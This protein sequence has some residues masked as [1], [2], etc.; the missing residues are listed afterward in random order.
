MPGLGAPPLGSQGDSRQ[1]TEA[2]GELLGTTGASLHSPFSRVSSFTQ[3]TPA[4][5]KTEEEMSA[6]HRRAQAGTLSPVPEPLSPALSSGHPATPPSLLKTR[7]CPSHLL[8]S[9][10][11]WGGWLRSMVDTQAQAGEEGQTPVCATG[12]HGD[13]SDLTALTRTAP[14]LRTGKGIFISPQ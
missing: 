11:S 14:Q 1:H 7:T 12:A 13:S 2:G 10:Q 4:S 8:A 3:T 6:P 5:R 9:P